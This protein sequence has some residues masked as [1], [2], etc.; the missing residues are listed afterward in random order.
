MDYKLE[1]PRFSWLLFG[2][3]NL[4]VSLNIFSWPPLRCLYVMC[5]NKLII[6]IVKQ[7]FNS[8]IVRHKISFNVSFITIHHE[9]FTDTLD[10]FGNSEVI[11]GGV[12]GYRLSV[13]NLLI[14]WKK[15]FMT[16]K[17]VL[18]TMTWVWYA[19]Q[20]VMMHTW[21]ACQPVVH[22][23]V[24]WSVIGLLLPVVMVSI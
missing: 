17:F 7:M 6:T 8:H 10:I 23:T 9:S 20:N 14:R 16:W 4:V 13:S 5:S 24:S 1:G 15:L 11:S 19:S 22:L 18:V 12:C 3:N 2:P 21:N